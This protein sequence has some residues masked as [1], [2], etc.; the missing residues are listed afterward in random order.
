M[1]G[2]HEV[3]ELVFV[4]GG[5]GLAATFLLLAARVL[6]ILAGLARV[7]G[8]DIDCQPLEMYLSMFSMISL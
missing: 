4:E 5:D 3:V 7:V 2:G 1:Q 8:K 6:H